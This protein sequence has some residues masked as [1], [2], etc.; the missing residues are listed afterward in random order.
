VLAGGF[1]RSTDDVRAVMAAGAAG[2]T[3]SQADLWGDPG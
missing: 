1:I 3:T 2:V